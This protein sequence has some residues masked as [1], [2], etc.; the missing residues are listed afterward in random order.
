[1]S[2]N[3]FRKEEKGF[4]VST[5]AGKCKKKERNAN[6]ENS[7]SNHRILILPLLSFLSSTATCESETQFVPSA[8]AEQ[9]G[10]SSK[11]NVLFTLP[12]SH[13]STLPFPN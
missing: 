10:T 2:S 1:M 11:V 7:S 6:K 3:S 9:F 5:H 12:P 4:H 8:Q 13:Y